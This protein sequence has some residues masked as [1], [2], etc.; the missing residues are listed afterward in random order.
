[1]RN[2]KMS[3]NQERGA[4]SVA[5]DNGSSSEEEYD[6]DDDFE[7][8]NDDNVPMKIKGL[9]DQHTHFKSINELFVYESAKNG[10]NILKLIKKFRMDMLDYIKLINFIRSQVSQSV[11]VEQ[12]K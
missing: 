9:F 7:E 8:I 1:M 4:R 11:L 6:D 12:T 2:L 10:F 5:N 3:V